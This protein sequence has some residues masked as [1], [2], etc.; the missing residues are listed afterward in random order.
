MD[1]I[2]EIARTGVESFL[3]HD[4]PSYAS[5]IAYQTLFALIPGVLA[6]IAL[7]GFLDLEDVWQNELR[8]Q[9]RDVMQSDSFSVLDRTVAHVLGQQRGTW[10]T[11]GLAFALW[12]IS[13]AVRAATGP[14]NLVYGDE[15]ERPW[16]K[17][18]LV[19]LALAP[20]LGACLALALMAIHF[21]PLLTE[22][23][24]LPR[25]VDL[26]LSILRWVVAVVLLFLF[27]WLVLRFAPAKPHTNGWTSFGAAFVVVAW[28]VASL[29]FAAYVTTL[30]NYGTL[31]GS[32]AAVIVL[33]VY[34][35]VS[36]LAF[37]VGIQLDACIRAQAAREQG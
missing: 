12:Q 30:A 24:D 35:Y 7:L 34:L 23:L 5:A 32:L 6:G 36:S 16:W 26:P 20:A 2:K 9:A 3:R 11:F 15:E 29:G 31:F 27:N 13:G 1:R 17:R 37:L 18:W 28:L 22:R 19:S 8:P 10:L 4:L 33:L 21:M 25:L 14:L